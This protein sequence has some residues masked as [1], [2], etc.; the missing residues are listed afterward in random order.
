MNIKLPKGA[1]LHLLFGPIGAGKSHIAQQVA[2]RYRGIIL[3]TDRFFE[4]L[5]LQDMSPQPDF[6][7]VHERTQRCET[8]MWQLTQQAYGK[9]PVILDAGLATK[10]SRRHYVRLCTSNQ[11]D[12]QFVYIDASESLRFERIESRNKKSN[13]LFVSHEIFHFTNQLFE[14]PTSDELTNLNAISILNE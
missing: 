14:H 1:P 9:V 10:E 5:F 8:T 4:S 6:S 12:Y 13:E 11:L 2:E 3:S 7:W